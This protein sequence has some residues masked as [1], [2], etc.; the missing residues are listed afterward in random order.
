MKTSKPQSI[1]ENIFSLAKLSQQENNTVLV[2][3]NDPRKD[4]LDKK[5][6]EVN[7]ISEKKMK[8]TWLLFLMVTLGHVTIAIMT[9]FI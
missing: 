7:I 4:H 6:K 3:S 5:G 9:A 1:P 2:S 8:L